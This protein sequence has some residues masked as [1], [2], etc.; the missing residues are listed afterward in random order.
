METMDSSFT[1]EDIQDR[2]RGYDPRFISANV[3]E[4]LSSSGLIERSD[5]VSLKF[6]RQ[7]QGSC[8]EGEL[9]D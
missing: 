7:G 8:R 4:L 6:T 3:K 1:V 2:L 9:L 5:N